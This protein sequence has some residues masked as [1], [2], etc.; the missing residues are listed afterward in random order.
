M[1]KQFLSPAASRLQN[2]ILK[3]LEDNK[4]INV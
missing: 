4:I 2:Y 3:Y 1:N